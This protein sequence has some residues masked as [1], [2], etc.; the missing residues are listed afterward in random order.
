MSYESE[1]LAY[2]YGDGPMPD[3]RR[4]PNPYNEYREDCGSCDACDERAEADRVYW[5][6][7]ALKGSRHHTE[8]GLTIIVFARVLYRVTPD[9]LVHYP[10]T[11]PYAEDPV[12]F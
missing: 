9:G 5:E 6:G 2:E 11:S 10:H 4:R 3:C 7:Q 12:P 8:M 1:L